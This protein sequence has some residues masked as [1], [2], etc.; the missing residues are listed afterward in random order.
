MGF[1]GSLCSIKSGCL[2][3]FDFEKHFTTKQ[4]KTHADRICI[5]WH[6]CSMANENSWGQNC[7]YHYRP[8]PRGHSNRM[9]RSWR[10]GWDIEN[11]LK[12]KSVSEVVRLGHTWSDIPTHHILRSD[13]S[14]LVLTIFLFPPKKCGFCL[15]TDTNFAYSQTSNR[16]TLYLAAF[17]ENAWNKAMWGWFPLLTIIPL[18]SRVRSL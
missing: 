10:S 6:Y 2:M 11:T 9:W 13:Q 4:Y 18:R 14:S 17:P 12:H 16:A 8:W 3:L 7:W 15:D 5:D 1:W